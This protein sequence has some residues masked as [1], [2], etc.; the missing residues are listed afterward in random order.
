MC[1]LR[2]CRSNGRFWRM[3][4][5]RCLTRW[6]RE[7]TVWR[8]HS[9]DTH[10]HCNVNEIRQTAH[11]IGSQVNFG[12]CAILTADSSTMWR[13]N[14]TFSNGTFYRTGLCHPLN[15]AFPRA[16]TFHGNWRYGPYQ[17]RWHHWLATTKK[18]LQISP[19]TVTLFKVTL[20]LKWHF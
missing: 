12:E 13:Q 10:N 19:L 18:S 9:W 5:L 11:F 17:L 15:P 6:H 8:A 14:G 16:H 7:S 4:Y 2:L 1:R 20:W 3:C